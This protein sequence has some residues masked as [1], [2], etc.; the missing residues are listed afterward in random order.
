MERSNKAVF[1]IY[2][3]RGEVES[4]VTTLKANGFRT[5]DISVLLIY[6]GR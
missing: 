2:K 1:G 3:T 4:A 5:S 6:M